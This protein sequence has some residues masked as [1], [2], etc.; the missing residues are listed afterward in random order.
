MSIEYA[1]TQIDARLVRLTDTP[2]TLTLPPTAWWS[3]TQVALLVLLIAYCV[4]MVQDVQRVRDLQAESP[5]LSKIIITKNEA[6]QRIYGRLARSTPPSVQ[7]RA[8]TGGA[9]T[10]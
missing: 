2:A 9:P 4:G 10:P 1:L 3:L 7:P 8:W 6:W 5:S